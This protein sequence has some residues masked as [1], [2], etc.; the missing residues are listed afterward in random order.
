MK[1]IK[2]KPWV[3]PENNAK[4]WA[5]PVGRERSQ[6]APICVYGKPELARLIIKLLNK[7]ERSR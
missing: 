2:L 1:R 3:Y 7:H 6:E 4:F 5:I